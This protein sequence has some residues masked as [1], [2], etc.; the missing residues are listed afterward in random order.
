MLL[1][2]TE[3]EVMNVMNSLVNIAKLP[4]CKLNEMKYLINLHDKIGQ[5]VITNQ[6]TVVPPVC[7]EPL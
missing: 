5:Q 4:M 3:D 6:K 7:E 2:L 1:D